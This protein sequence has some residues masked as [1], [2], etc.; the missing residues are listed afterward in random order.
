[1]TKNGGCLPVEIGRS[2][3]GDLL[4]SGGRPEEHGDFGNGKR[5]IDFLLNAISYMYDTVKPRYAPYYSS[6]LRLRRSEARRR[7]RDS[8]K[9]RSVP[10]ACDIGLGDD[11]DVYQ[12]RRG[13]RK[14]TEIS[15]HYK[16]SIQTR[17][18]LFFE[19]LT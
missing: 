15:R 9:I 7:K 5:K 10:D 8:K 16:T 12:A 3:R 19:G 11:V 14:G 6:Y 13:A 4:L 2:R 18:P 17:T 1:M